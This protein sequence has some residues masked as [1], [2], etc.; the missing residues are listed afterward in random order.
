M[1]NER[2]PKKPYQRDPIKILTRSYQAQVKKAH[3]EIDMCAKTGR[4]GK[5]TMPNYAKEVIAPIS[6]VMGEKMAQMKITVSEQVDV[7]A[8]KDGYFKVTAGDRIIGGFSYPGPGVN[9][10]HFTIFAHDK[11]WGRVIGITK[12]SQLMRIITELVE[13]HG[14]DNS[15]GND[16]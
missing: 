15:N 7:S 16:K 12:L 4:S 1:E 13:F 10:I 2:K 14:F 11:P 8:G 3:R 6:R 5:I 9:W